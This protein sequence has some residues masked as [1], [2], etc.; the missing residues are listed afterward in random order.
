VVKAITDFGIFID[1]GGV[2]GLVHITDLS[3]GRVNHPSEVV[4]LDQEMN[5]V[6]LDFDENKKR[7][8]LGLKQ[9][10]PHPWEIL[11]TGTRFKRGHR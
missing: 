2:D 5:V 10:Q 7:I 11:K 9:L 4:K 3:W 1:L 8:S 6:V